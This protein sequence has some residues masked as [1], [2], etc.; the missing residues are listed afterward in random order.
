MEYVQLQNNIL[1]YNN[2]SLLDFGMLLTEKYIRI[3]MNSIHTEV[4][5][6]Y[7]LLTNRGTSFV[8]IAQTVYD[9]TCCIIKIHCIIKS[10]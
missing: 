5:N 1:E 2:F 6:I 10:T 7:Y 9:F 4:F 3:V 8:C